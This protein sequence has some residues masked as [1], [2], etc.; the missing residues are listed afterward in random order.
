MEQQQPA[1]AVPRRRNWKTN[2]NGSIILAVIA[3]II[4]VLLFFK[5]PSDSAVATAKQET[6]NAATQ[7]VADS[8]KNLRQEIGNLD[9]KFVFGVRDELKQYVSFMDM[10]GNVER[11]QFVS[12]INLWFHR[13]SVGVYHLDT[14]D[15]PPETTRTLVPIYYLMAAAGRPIQPVLAKIDT[16]NE[17]YDQSWVRYSY[18]YML[19]PPGTVVTSTSSTQQPT[20]VQQAV[21]AK[22]TASKKPVKEI[23]PD[24][25]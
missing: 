7:M 2:F 15:D 16:T 4:G 10:F 3:L 6:I 17:E 12:T 9:A 19:P 13:D 20:T 25:F 14:Q 1:P 22:D 23:L 8:T 11:P 5:A 24:I 21:A 18:A